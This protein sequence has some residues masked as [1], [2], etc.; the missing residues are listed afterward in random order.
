MSRTYDIVIFG[1]TGFSGTLML[2]YYVDNPTEFQGLKIAVA[3]RNKAK[4]EAVVGK[5]KADKLVEVLVADVSN[6]E[7]LAALAKSTKVLIACAGPFCLL[8]EPPLKA[9]VEAGTHYV[10]ITGEGGWIRNMVQQYDAKAKETGALVLSACGFD[11]VPADLLARFAVEQT[12]RQADERIA[13][14]TAVQL[15]MRADS[16]KG[17]GGV[18]H[19]TYQTM[20]HGLATGEGLSPLA[21]HKVSDPRLSSSVQLDP[22]LNAALFP[23]EFTSDA[24]LVRRTSALLDGE[25]KQIEYFH[26]LNVGFRL[27][28]YLMQIGFAIFAVLCRIPPLLAFLKGRMQVGDGASDE[29]RANARMR[30]SCAVRSFAGKS[31]TPTLRGVATMNIASDGYNVTAMTAMQC[32]RLLSKRAAAKGKGGLMTP[33]AALG[34]DLRDACTQGGLLAL[35]WEP[36]K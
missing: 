11:S 1:V 16:S 25:S 19:G 4:V 29:D 5:C 15:G 35:S 31:S 27:V 24:Y 7:S 21:D 32:A 9:C 12:D 18:S 3:G 6:A 28:G 10:D 14:V 33:V 2:R 36:Q 8:G 20:L 22:A 34:S 30:M 13:L 26:G 17:F 23:F